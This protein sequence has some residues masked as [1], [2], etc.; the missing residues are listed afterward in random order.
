MRP[1]QPTV[2]TRDLRAR[3][4]TREEIEKLRAL[5]E[6]TQFLAWCALLGMQNEN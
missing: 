1:V 4:I 2:E 6:V 5:F 3:A